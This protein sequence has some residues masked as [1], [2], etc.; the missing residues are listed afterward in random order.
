MKEIEFRLSE[1]PSK[2][3]KEIGNTVNQYS[4]ALIYTGYD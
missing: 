2:F 3:Q 1:L 4:V